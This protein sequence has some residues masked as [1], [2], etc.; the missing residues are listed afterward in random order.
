[1]SDW[2]DVES[3]IIRDKLSQCEQK[4]VEL[5][6]RQAE[7]KA[8]LSTLNGEIGTL[9]TQV[10]NL[11]LELERR[12]TDKVDARISDHALLRYVERVLEI[13]VEKLR[14]HLLSKEIRCAIEAG[15]KSVTIDGIKFIVQGKT[16]VTM[17]APEQKKK[18]I[19]KCST[20]RKWACE[21]DV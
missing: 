17:I 18:S 14:N 16:I 7:A 6:R 9:T 21:C 11:R 19:S 15:A 4:R 13:D 1:M 3:D 2:R 12:N 8:R 5:H 10:N 20:C